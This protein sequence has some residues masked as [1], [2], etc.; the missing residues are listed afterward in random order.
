MKKFTLKKIILAL[1]IGFSCLLQAQV[2]NEIH[3]D[4]LETGSEGDALSSDVTT[5]TI[6]A[7]GAVTL[8]GLATDDWAA[9]G[10]TG[11]VTLAGA[12]NKTFKIYL[13]AAALINTTDNENFG[14][15]TTLGGVDRAGNGDLGIRQGANF[16]ITDGEGLTFGFDA[17]NLD[18]SVTIQIT[19]ISLSTF[20]A[21]GEQATFVNR[22]DTSKRLVVTTTTNGFKD[23][24]G[25]ELYVRGGVNLQ[26][27]VSVFATGGTSNFRIDAIKF[28][29]VESST[30]P[31][32]WIGRTTDFGDAQNWLNNT[33]PISSSNVTIQNY[34]N[35]PVIFGTRNY[36]VNDLSIAKGTDLE[37]RGGGTLIVNGTSTGNV[38]Y[39]RDL[40][41]SA[42]PTE[43]WYLVS[44]PVTG[45][46]FNDDFVA[47]YDIAI[48]GGGNRGIASYNPAS[49]NW[50]YLTSGGTIN[51]TAGIG[52]SFKITP[53][54]V[55]TSPEAGDGQVF[56]T[57]TLNTD[58]AGVTTSGLSTGFNLVGNPYTSYVNSATFLA[59]NA[60]IDQ[61][62]I[63]L[64]NQATGNYNVKVAGD[65]F[66][67]APTQGFFINVVSGTTVNFA[68]SNQASGSDTFQKESR[69]EVNLL[70]NDGVSNR[71]A[72]LYYLDTATKGFDSGWEGET[73]GG[74][75]NNLDIFTH[76]VSDNNGKNYQLQSLPIAEMETII[77]PVG[78]KAAA[79]KE[80]TFTAEAMNLPGDTKV[81]LEDRLANTL[82]R[83]DEAN[84]SYKITLNDALNGTGR[85]FLH[86]KASGVLSTD[87]AILESVSIYT[88]NKSTLRIAGLAQGK[89]TVKVFNI[90]GKQ[91]MQTS[92]SSSG[93]Q[94]ISL[95]K[96][97]TGM[98]I[99]QLETAKGKLNKKIVLE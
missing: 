22:M 48:S 9:I 97:A 63:W 27:L 96:L 58:N 87:D 85:F 33:T 55:T 80:I 65:A 71:Y 78:I 84:A 13:R 35:E 68:E 77:V 7:G 98:Y 86:T 12:L 91:V 52:Y 26:D 89:A 17:S 24:A 41:N 67:L 82:T 53:D 50:S 92:F 66:K 49:N 37:I 79:G 70:M 11:T 36:Q 64:W 76:L 5:I 74:I 94:D 61:T 95:P 56:F 8:P 20:T 30:L 31:S 57:G 44:S 59:D 72:K 23:V 99:V 90:L 40:G 32:I 29:I 4:A 19:S 46:T 18:T 54:G 1:A 83:L 39:R 6:S 51:S 81:F 15:I 2:D 28:K 38:S 47:N 88:P 62:Q 34:N 16:G 45:V 69:T 73:F 75:P 21:A 25:L 10:T 60:N 14:D 43:A 93:V 42:V 3:L